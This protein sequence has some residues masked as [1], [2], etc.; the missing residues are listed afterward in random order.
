M[1]A[2]KIFC[3]GFNKTGTTTLHT[4]LKRQLK[5]RSVHKPKWPYWSAD[6]GPSELD[7]FEAFTDGETPLINRLRVRYPEAQF[8]VNTRPLIAWVTSRHKAVE[9]VKTVVTWLLTKYVPVPLLLRYV[10]RKFLVNDDRAMIRWIQIRNSYHRFV[11]NQLGS[12]DAF[13]MINI[14]DEDMLKDLSSFIRTQK[15]LRPITKN[16]DGDA[17]ITARVME[18]VGEKKSSV[19]S[20]AIVQD[21]FERHGITEHAQCLTYFE[22]EGFLLTRSSA[23]KFLSIFPFMRPLFRWLFVRLVRRRGHSVNLFSKW[24]VDKCIGMVRSEE[25]MNYYISIHQYGSGSR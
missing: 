14:E 24:L 22:K 12:T 9:R 11:M 7:N 20:S 4:V 17:S 18:A 1:E 6:S 5:V 19:D 15:A 10:L 13:L 25:D 2:R 21:F 16:K 3:I 8:I 23:D